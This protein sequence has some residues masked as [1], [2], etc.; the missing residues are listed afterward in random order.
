M[1]I[2]YTL[3]GATITSAQLNIPNTNGYSRTIISGATSNNSYT[4]TAV[5]NT[6]YYTC[7]FRI[8]S[9]VI[10]YSFK[11]TKDMIVEN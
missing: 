1:Y 10:N 4:I 8:S 11:F 5:S 3:S 9:V 6:T 2:T 7:W